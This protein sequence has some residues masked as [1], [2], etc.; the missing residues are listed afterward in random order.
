MCIVYKDH[1]NDEENNYDKMSWVEWVKREWAIRGGVYI[2][3]F[4]V[5]FLGIVPWVIGLFKMFV[6]GLTK[7]GG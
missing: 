6:W 7:I 3:L 1:F 2:V 5:V 4:I